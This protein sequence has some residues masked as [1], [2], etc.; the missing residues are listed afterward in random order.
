[1]EDCTHAKAVTYEVEGGTETVC[2]ACK[3]ITK[4]A[5]E[6]T[7]V[8][9]FDLSG[10]NMTLGN[11]LKINVAVKTELLKDGYIAKITHGDTT[12]EA[13]FSKYNSTLSTVS[14]SVSAKQMAD[15]LTV[16]VFDANGNAVSNPYEV[17]VR[18]YAMKMLGTTTKQTMQTLLVDMLNYGAEAQ[19]YFKYNEADLANALLTDEQKAYA[20]A[21]VACSNKQVKGDNVFGTNLTLGDQILL[22]VGF[23]NV[24]EGMYA[25]IEFTDYRGEGKSI[26]VPFNE[27]KPFSGSKYLVVVDDIVL[28][29]AF[30]LVTVTVYNADGTVHGSMTDSV[31]S[32]VARVGAT[33]L[34]G[35]IMKFAYS[36]REYLK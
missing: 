4:E 34:N 2:P 25:T 14:Y 6:E 7:P 17:S 1:M 30:S 12:I 3:L 11:E 18:S 22:N 28:A 35:A 31:E 19:K 23:N 20:T 24:A 13:A 21:D 29:D 15:T 5:K 27:F 26:E 32:Y 9:K 36:A 10:A 16:E 33:D 8:E